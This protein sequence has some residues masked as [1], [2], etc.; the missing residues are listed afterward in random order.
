MMNNETISQIANTVL[1]ILA[2]P[3]LYLITVN[4]MAFFKPSK[5]KQQQKERDDKSCRI[6]KYK[7]IGNLRM[8]TECGYCAENK[9]YF[10]TDK[11]KIQL[12][13]NVELKALDEEKDKKIEEIIERNGIDRKKLDKVTNE[14]SSALDELQY[15]KQKKINH[16]IEIIKEQG[17]DNEI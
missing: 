13:L 17:L 2:F 12:D 1:I 6:H 8:C 9:F 10:N 11:I 4:L 7:R 3:I 16:Y 15:Q 5:F 14:M